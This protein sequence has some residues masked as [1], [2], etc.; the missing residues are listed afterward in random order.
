MFN[1]KRAACFLLWAIVSGGVRKASRSV[2][3]RCVNHDRGVFE[4]RDGRIVELAP[5]LYNN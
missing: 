1:L 3:L 2:C 4:A 5:V